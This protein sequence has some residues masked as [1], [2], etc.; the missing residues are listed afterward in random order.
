MLAD[1]QPSGGIHLRFNLR[2]ANWPGDAPT[3]IVCFRV[4]DEAVQKTMARALNVK[5]DEVR[6]LPNY[7]FFWRDNIT[8]AVSR[9]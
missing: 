2:P 4:N 7:R 8:G 6:D 5:V 1:H 3:E 9:N